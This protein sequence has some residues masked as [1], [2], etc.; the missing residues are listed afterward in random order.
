MAVSPVPVASVEVSPANATIEVGRTL[1]LA[2]TAKDA[3][4]NALSGRTITW[5]SSDDPVATVSGTGSVTV[6]EE[7]RRRRNRDFLEGLST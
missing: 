6:L 3:A 2:V 4:G 7:N 5:V 1:Q